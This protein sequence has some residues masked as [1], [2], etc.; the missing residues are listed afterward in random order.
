M[1]KVIYIYWAQKFI[2]APDIVKKCLLSW[3]SKNPTWKIIE[4][5]DNNLCD[6]IDIKKEIP[7]FENKQIT[8]TSYSDIIRIFLLEKYGG[9]WC[10]ATTFCIEPLDNWLH[11]YISSG[12][13]GFNKP[14]KSRLIS[15]WF[16]YSEKNNYIIQKWREK[17]IIY[18]NNHNKVEEYFWFHY[19]FNTLYSHDKQFNYIWDL[20]PKISAVHPHFLQHNGLL[21]HIT[22]KVI[23]HIH[24]KLSPLYKLTYKYDVNK[25]HNKC[26]LNY[27]LK[28][29]NV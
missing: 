13:F 29:T 25:Y 2:N 8:K 1:I 14:C 15:S 7:N 19:I 17:T 4:L 28:H 22:N 24:N 20:T 3:K 11:K 27:L 5:D 10:D 21:N 16:L 6:Y 26:N 18:W 9:C 12:F 23:F